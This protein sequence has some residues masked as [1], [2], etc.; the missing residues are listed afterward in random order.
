[1]FFAGFLIVSNKGAGVYKTERKSAVNKQVKAALS[2]VRDFI[3]GHSSEPKV[4]DADDQALRKVLAAELLTSISRANEPS[5]Q[6]EAGEGEATENTQGEA[7][8]LK[9]E[10]ERSRQLFMEHGYFDEAVQNLRTGNSA[11][12]RAAAARTLG[13]VGSQRATADLIAAMF[14]RDA[15]VRQAADEALTQIGD[16]TVTKAP[17][18]EMPITE[19]ATESQI[20]EASI[21]DIEASLPG[22]DEIPTTEVNEDVAETLPAPTGLAG[23]A[24]PDTLVPQV[25]QV[26]TVQPSIVDEAEAATEEEQLLLEEH[27]VRE[28]VEQYERQLIESAAMR[29]KA[30]NEAQ[31][32]AE[33]EAKIRVEAEARRVDEETRR[34]QAEAEAARR[35]SVEAEALAL[36][37]DAR[38]QAEAEVHRLAEEEARLRL[39]TGN[40]RHAAEELARQRRQI[41]IA[42]REAAEA[43]RHAEATRARQE[44]EKIHQTEVERLQNEEQALRFAIEETMKRR[45]ELETSRQKAEAEITSLSEERNQLIAAAEAETKQLQEERERLFEG[46]TTR[47]AEAERLRREAA[48]R[49]RAEEEQ[50]QQQLDAL[51]NATN[52]IAAR[53]AEIEIAR[54][55]AEQDAEQ[56]AEALVRMRAADEARARAEQER[57]QVEAATKEQLETEQRLLKE[58]RRRALEEQARLEEERRRHNEAEEQRIAALEVAH[59]KAEFEEKQ[60]A[61]KEKQIHSEIDHIRIADAEARRRIE[62]AESLRRAFE[63]AYQRAAEKVQRME[64][65]AHAAT[66]QEELMLTKLETARRNLANEAQARAAQEKRVKEEIEQFHRL[67]D[68]ERPRLEAA[69]LQRTAAAARLQQMKE[70]SAEVAAQTEEEFQTATVFAS[71]SAAGDAGPEAPGIVPGDVETSDRELASLEERV[72]SG[73]QPAVGAY[74]NSVDPYKRAAAVWELSRS[75]GKEAFPM[76]ANCFDDHSVHVRNAAARAL[77][78]LEPARTID[79]FNRALDEGSE[80]RRRNIGSAIASSGL[81]K[82]SINNL[83]SESREATYNALSILFVMAKTGETEPLVHAIEEHGNDEVRKAVV[84]LLTL[85]G[86]AEI[87]DAAMKRREDAQKR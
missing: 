68:E 82:E 83:A 63:Q 54:A 23:E 67:Q 27:A 84:K 43:A 53:R 36:E 86:Q 7:E 28:T 41:E 22:T 52:E 19:T 80:E 79:F 38:E 16:P 85:S 77:C 37:H 87:A 15:E 33:R 71:D 18:T 69:I 8:Q 21:H 76:I 3:S 49:K 34:K 60:R 1:V 61:E 75:Q 35:R 62:D 14:D 31:W 58:A 4:P 12:D 59:R 32:R 5:R 47:R 66:Q 29:Q 72:V 13:L 56:L 64:A 70:H 30:E 42:R 73:V 81:A 17:I 40:L 9:L 24:E 10:Q 50:L 51:S 78:Q 6:L 45:S 74:L 39:E 48:E 20:A 55:K 57:L 65:E 11:A 44:A 26:E 25:L 2:A 46:E